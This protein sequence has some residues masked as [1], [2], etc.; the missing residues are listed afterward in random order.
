MANTKD[1]NGVLATIERLTG[2]ALCPDGL[3]VTLVKYLWE[4]E[5]FEGGRKTPGKQQGKL[6][7]GKTD[8]LVMNVLNLDEIFAGSTQTVRKIVL[9]ELSDADL[10]ARL[11][12]AADNLQRRRDA[13]DYWA[14]RMDALSALLVGEKPDLR[15]VRIDDALRSVPEFVES[16]G[17]SQFALH[18]V[19]RLERLEERGRLGAPSANELTEQADAYFALGDYVTANEK[20]TRAVEI[21]PKQSRAWFIRV[22]VLLRQRNAAANLM[23]RHEINAVEVAEPMS[24]HETM[25]RELADD[26]GSTAYEAQVALNEVVP[27]ALLDWPKTDDGALSYEHEDQL[28]MI[29]NLF[30]DVV[31]TK[32]AGRRGALLDLVPEAIEVS[33]SLMRPCDYWRQ[34]E[35]VCENSPVLT[36]FERRALK[37]LFDERRRHTG[38]Y[39]EMRTYMDT[40]REFK[41][42]HLS[43]ALR[44]DGYQVQWE[45]LR[46]RFVNWKSVDF[47]KHILSD[48]RLSRLWQFHAVNI[49]GMCGVLASLDRWHATSLEERKT[50]S[51]SLALRTLAY[52]F[53][54]RLV[55]GELAQ[56][57]DIALHAQ[58]LTSE[59][60]GIIGYGQIRMGSPDDDSLEM[61][62]GCEL[63]WKYLEALTVVL[64]PPAQV[65][66]RALSLLLDAERWMADF[67]DTGRCFWVWEDYDFPGE[68][69]S[70]PYGVD[71]RDT[72]RWLQAVEAYVEAFPECDDMERLR[73]VMGRLEIAKG[74]FAPRE[75]T[76]FDP[77]NPG[78]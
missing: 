4:E 8:A 77:E 17:T 67:R 56:C 13:Y 55:R 65:G 1:P 21:D 48:D 41:L 24:V 40:A 73:G 61:P 62:I 68:C 75:P 38:R 71:L 69:E 12:S 66:D 3:R 58:S 63:Y 43:W 36:T 59:T 20:A 6:E 19:Q 57:A 26:A 27:R 72:G 54:D 11:K 28:S 52:V 78:H 30:V 22:M 33:S 32:V 16:C 70:A 53:H 2:Q 7:R 50:R 14:R 76:V 39:T 18:A 15:K 44:L 46:Q 31:F 5:L 60:T 9:G 34:E 47:R 29:R 49:D 37:L 74:I 10:T 42:L 35:S 64:M 45:N 25:E 23:R 51:N